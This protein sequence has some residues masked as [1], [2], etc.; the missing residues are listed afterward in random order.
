MWLLDVTKPNVSLIV[1]HFGYRNHLFLVLMKLK[2]G[3]MNRDLAIRFNLNEAKVSKIF[4]KWIKP[5]A[6]LLKNLIVCLDREA[7]RK[8]LPSSFS[9]FKNCVCIIDCI[10]IFIE[11]PQNQLARAQVYSNYKSHNTVK[12]LIRITL[13]GA[14]SFL[15][16]GWGGS[17][18][19]KMIKLNSG[20]LEMVSHFGR[21]WFFN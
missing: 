3:L 10:E 9:S 7:V 14:V 13:A 16:Y 20:F 19:D 5:L 15:S 1:Q 8:N 17:A 21:L 2:L 6:I 11:Q 18:S 4:W 12:Y